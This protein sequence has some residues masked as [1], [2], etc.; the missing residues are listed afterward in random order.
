MLTKWNSPESLP[1]TDEIVIVLFADMSICETKGKDIVFRDRVAGWLPVANVKE[2]VEPGRWFETRLTLP[3]GPS[4]LVLAY[5]KEYNTRQLVYTFELVSRGYAHWAEIP[6]A[7][8]KKT[9]VV[10]GKTEYTTVSDYV[11]VTIWGEH[12]GF[13]YGDIP[14]IDR[15]AVWNEDG[16]Y[17]GT[18]KIPGAHSCDL[19]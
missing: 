10:D 19:R 9:W 18:P 16:K 4:R 13:Y 14:G 6:D 7:P 5:R 12:G 3:S 17:V 11:G 1:K 2:Y 8:A 15:H